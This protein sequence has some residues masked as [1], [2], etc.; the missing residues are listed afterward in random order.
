[1]T[2]TSTLDSFGRGS[3]TQGSED[4]TLDIYTFLSTKATDSTDKA[5][6]VAANNSNNITNFNGAE[7]LHDGFTPTGYDV[8]VFEAETPSF[9]PNDLLNFTSSLQR[10]FHLRVRRGRR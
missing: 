5:L 9:G 8:Y 4:T 1:V 7:Q 2:V 3:Y 10:Y 6:F